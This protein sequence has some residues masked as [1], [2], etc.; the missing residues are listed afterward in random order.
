MP[1]LCLS[2]SSQFLRVYLF[3]SHKC[4]R[5]ISVHSFFIS[6]LDQVYPYLAYLL[7]KSWKSF[8]LLDPYFPSFHNSSIILSS[9]IPCILSINSVRV[10]SAACL[11]DPSS[12][13]IFFQRFLPILSYWNSPGNPLGF[14]DFFLN[15]I[16][17][18]IIDRVIF[19]TDC[20]A[21]GGN[22]RRCD[23]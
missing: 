23:S 13:P 18:Q 6:F 1:L 12:F 15:R 19:C 10:T 22:S 21:L 2:L 5:Y 4:E 7:S 17:G 11:K 3:F 20:R 8:V 14:H 9:C 16:G